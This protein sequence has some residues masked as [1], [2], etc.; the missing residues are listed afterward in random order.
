MKNFKNKN[1]LITGGASGIGKLSGKMLMEKGAQFIIWD[2]NTDN[3]RTA[4]KEL[5]TL[6][7]VV[8]YQVDITDRQEVKNTYKRTVEEQGHID[9]LINNAG[10]ITAGYF[11]ELTENDIQK[12]MEVNALAPM[13]LTRLALQDMM[14][15]NQ[16]SILNVSSSAGLVANPRMTAYVASKWSIFGWSDSLRLEMKKLKKNIHITTF[17]PYYIDTG[18][19]DG[20]KS[21]IPLIKPEKAARKIVRSIEKKRTIVAMPWNMQ[22]VRFWQGILPVKGF[23]W[24]MDNLLGIY[25]TM[26]AFKG[27]SK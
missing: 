23:D 26:D 12:T 13:Y 14:Q 2:V 5:E 21:Q 16:G 1:V 7:K 8:A 4:L 11:H 3:I 22:F 6:G 18:M 17:A 27:R 15:R 19:F 24:L 20:V 25:N 10:I 9:I